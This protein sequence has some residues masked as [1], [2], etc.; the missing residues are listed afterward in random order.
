[1]Q[2]EGS[3]DPLDLIFYPQIQSRSGKEYNNNTKKAFVF[4]LC[5]RANYLRCR[6][7]Q[8]I[9]FQTT[10]CFFF[11]S[12]V[13]SLCSTSTTYYISKGLI[14]LKSSI[15]EA[16]HVIIMTLNSFFQLAIS[17]CTAAEECVAG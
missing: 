14:F 4:V 17:F 9:L 12:S 7:L 3:K 1:M 5:R 16:P 8:F 11:L 15:V 6:L 10:T 13:S 2:E